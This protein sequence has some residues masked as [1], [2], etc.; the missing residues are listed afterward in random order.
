MAR[1]LRIAAMYALPV[2]ATAAASHW[3]HAGQRA[4]EDMHVV[5]LYVPYGEMRHIVLPDNSSVHLN[6]GATL[7]YPHKF[8]GRTRSIYLSGEAK[9]TIAP[10]KDKPFIVKTNDIDVTATGTVFNVSS[11]PDSRNAVATLVEG[12]IEVSVKNEGTTYCLHHQEQIVYDREARS[13]K[14][15][16]IRTDAVGEWEK[17]LLAFRSAPLHNIIKEIERH[18]DVRICLNSTNLGNEALTVKFAE[19]ETLAD[20][21]HTIRQLVPDLKYKIEN[22]T[23]YIINPVIK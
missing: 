18:F 1:V 13:V 7:F 20:V 8:N 22:K 16:D 3:W 12:S 4:N 10:N 15:R 21:L 11:Y 9:F 14:R 6:S 19:N 2:L 23:V 5:E 17:G